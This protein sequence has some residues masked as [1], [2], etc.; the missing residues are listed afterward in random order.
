[1]R[2][3]DADALLKKALD[4]AFFDSAAED[5]FC[6]L[7]ETAPTVYAVEVVRCKEC[8]QYDP[9][10]AAVFGSVTFLTPVCNK[11]ERKLPILRAGGC[12]WGERRDDDA[13]DI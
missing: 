2:L 5:T 10:F 12:P 6:E 4:E 13:A 7:V 3:I 9:E 1:M 8:K 11:F